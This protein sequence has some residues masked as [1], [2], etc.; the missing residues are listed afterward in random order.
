MV[1][2]RPQEGFVMANNSVLATSYRGLLDA[3]AD[4]RRTWDD[5]VGL[6][7]DVVAGSGHLE[8]V[9]LVELRQR[10]EAHRMAIDVL[11][12]ALD[13]TALVRAEPLT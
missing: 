7:T 4:A 5:V 8:E 10:V 3:F 2:A 9:N 1:A 6:Q 12:D 13:T 11:V